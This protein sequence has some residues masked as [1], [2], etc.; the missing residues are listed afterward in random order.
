VSHAIIALRL[1]CRGAG[2]ARKTALLA[3]F[4]ADGMAVLRDEM[5]GVMVGGT[6][7]PAG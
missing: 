5:E 6:R 2:S 4:E 7:M 3:D 1:D